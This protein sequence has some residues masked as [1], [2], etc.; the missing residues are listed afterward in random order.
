MDLDKII[1]NAPTV[2]QIS[3]R[4]QGE[5]I[6]YNLWDYE[7]SNCKKVYGREYNFCPNCGAQMLKGDTE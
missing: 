2:P 5:W 3:G 1:D 4:T 6:P 7:C